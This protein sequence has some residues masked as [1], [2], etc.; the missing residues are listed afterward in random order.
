MKMKEHSKQIRIKV[1]QKHQSGVGYKNISKALTISQS[2]VKSIIKKWREYGTTV[3]LSRTGRP[4]KLSIRA[5]RALV[6]EATKSP[7]AT[8]KELQC[9]TAELGDTVHTATIA[10]VLHKTGLY[11]RV[12]KRKPLLKKTCIKSRLEFPRRHV[13]D[14]ETKWKKILW[15]DETK[16]EPFGLNAKR[17]VWRKPNTAHHPENTIPTVKHGGGSIMLWGCFSASGPGKLVKIEGKMD[18]VK[19]REILKENLLKSARDLGLGRRFIFQQDNDPKHTAKATL[20][21]L[22]NKKVN[23]LEWPSQSPDLNPI[24]NMWKELKIA[25]H[26]RSPSNLTELEQFCK[27]EW[28]KIAVSR[29]AKLVETY[30]NRLMAVIAA[31]GAS[32]KY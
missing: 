28:A 12:A 32:T 17:Y 31:K 6:R 24:E 16:I 25:V 7:M 11:G 14:S 21:W 20:E 23:V 13:G 26:Q 15:F 10:R 1:L 27:E 5:R 19:Y 29:C 9:S 22:K 4:Q 30:P 18:A 8:L 3:N 2:T